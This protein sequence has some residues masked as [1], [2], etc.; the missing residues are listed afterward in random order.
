MGREKRIEV[1]IILKVLSYTSI[2]LRMLEV[3]MPLQKGISKGFF[4]P[5]LF[6]DSGSSVF[7]AQVLNKALFASQNHQNRKEKTQKDSL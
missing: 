4:Q 6:G 5:L 1:K 2:K 3:L 7:N